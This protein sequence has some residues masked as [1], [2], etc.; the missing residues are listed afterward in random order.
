MG[1][2]FSSISEVLSGVRLAKSVK[3]HVRNHE[4]WTRWLEIVGNELFRVTSPANL[5]GKTLMVHVAH[6]AWAQQLHFLKPSILN[7]IRGICPSSNIK[8]ILFRVGEIENQSSG[9]ISVPF[10]KDTDREVKLTERQEMTLRAVEDPDL[11]QS[12]RR[13]ME[14]ERRRYPN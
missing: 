3:D 11:R 9:R 7:K 1:K 13:A 10:S 2:D 14:A 4:I 5:D 12:I 8:D 6:Q